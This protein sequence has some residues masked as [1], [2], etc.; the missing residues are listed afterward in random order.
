MEDI[1]V[2]QQFK[3]NSPSLPSPT[4][5][6]IASISGTRL[7]IRSLT[8]LEI[9][10]SIPLPSSH[11]LRNSRLCW[12][13][14]TTSTCGSGIATPPRRG[15]ALRSNRILIADDETTRV[16]D[17][18][19]D[20][21]NAVISNGSGGMGKNVHVEF[22]A[23][24]DEVVVF[25]DFQSKIT[26]WCLRSGRTVEIKDPKY[27]SGRG[28]GYR[29]CGE[30]VGSEEGRGKSGVLAVLCRNSGQDV[31]ILL[32][33]RTYKVLKRVELRTVDA[34][35]LKWSGDGS[36]VA[37]WDSSGS[38]YHLHIYTADGHLYRTIQRETQ[39]LSSEFDIEGLGIKTV[40][41]LPGNEFLAIGG[42]DRR[43]RMLSTRTFAPALFLDHTAQICVPKCQ[44]YKEQIDATRSRTYVLS[45]QP[46]LPPKAEIGKDDRSAM[47]K[48]GISIIAVNTD[49]TLCA[50]RD[51]ST[52]TVV[53]IWDLRSL[54]PRTILIQHSPIKSLQWHPTNPSLL[55]IQIFQDSPTVYLYTAPSVLFHST[56]EAVTLTPPNILDLS[57]QISKPAGSL[58]AKWT[59]SWLPTPMD[60]KPFFVFGHQQ[61][62]TLI[63]PEGKDQILRFEGED[64]EESEDSLYDILTGRTPVPKLCETMRVDYGDSEMED[65]GDF[66]GVGQGEIEGMG[67]PAK[68]GST[69]SFEDTFRERRRVVSGG[70]VRQGR[71]RE[72]GESV[73]DESGMSEMF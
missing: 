9:I 39:M 37:I 6:H 34:Q 15:L 52:P 60:K 45:P 13:P 41:W 43:V 55:L 48:Q 10:R 64:G 56:S 25:S 69:G 65:S 19:D 58:P 16:Y 62:Y 5:Q 46:I 7:H 32:A 67:L 22:G 40:D 4:A 42:W 73:F 8:S 51:D 63:W 68:E 18:R 29:P 17:V 12:S 11:D 28:W 47:P 30:V 14:P 20:K 53:W 2:S 24:E 49:A 21:W 1:E 72:R 38:G 59:A 27:S 66:L 50:T 33:P 57:S 35:G 70:G 71:G 31:M 36:W 23:S 61:A 3:T 26:V 44:V 54:E